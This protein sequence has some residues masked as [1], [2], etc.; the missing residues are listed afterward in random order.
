MKKMRFQRSATLGLMMLA[1]TGCDYRPF[2]K[3]H[4]CNSSGENSELICEMGSRIP[5]ATRGSAARPFAVCNTSWLADDLSEDYGQL[6]VIALKDVEANGAFAQ[7][8]GRCDFRA[9]LDQITG[10]IMR[11]GAEPFDGLFVQVFS[12]EP[13][14]YDAQ[15]SGLERIGMQV[16]SYRLDSC[17]ET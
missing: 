17:D 16:R 9:H 14:D 2:Y 10:F 6:M 13:E 5:F 3:S 15:V 1:C 4:E 12:C 8:G 7:I 11:S